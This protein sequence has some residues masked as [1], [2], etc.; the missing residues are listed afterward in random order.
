MVKE[1]EISGNSQVS[2]WPGGLR[3]EEEVSRY[4][5]YDKNLRSVLLQEGRKLSRTQERGIW[6]SSVK[7]RFE[8][9]I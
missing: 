6:G 8:A 9:C 3:G 4:H 1:K 5:L 7:L 2:A